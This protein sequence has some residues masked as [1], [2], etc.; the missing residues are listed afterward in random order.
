MRC[1]RCQGERFTNEGRDREGRPV[2]RCGRCRR[3][4]TEQGTSAFAGYRFPPDV[5]TPAV[6]WYLRFRL[7]YADV[8]ELP[9]ERGVH[10]DPSTIYDWVRHFA[11]L[12]QEAVRA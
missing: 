6:R 10:V 1:R 7:S 8:A 9:A 11:Q 2:Y 12:D 4:R 3:R 5:I